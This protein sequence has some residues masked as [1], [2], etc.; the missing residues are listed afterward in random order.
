MP[1]PVTALYLSL[2]ALLMLVFAWGVVRLRR[3]EKIGLGAG[4]SKGL[5]VAI[6]VHGNFLEYAPMVLLLLA[7]A[8]LNGLSPLY[9]H[10]L[11]AS[12]LIARI[13]HGIGLTQGRGGYHAGR[14]Y[15]TLL[16]WILVLVLALINLAQWGFGLGW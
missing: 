8:E 5:E 14:F 9:L 10:V 12:W 1:L 6:R 4:H 16:T 7:C 15:G 13:L 3:S 11:G 2:S